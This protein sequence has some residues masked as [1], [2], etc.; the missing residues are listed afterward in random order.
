MKYSKLIYSCVFGLSIV[1]VE[2]A[3]GIANQL[4]LS[5]LQGW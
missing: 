3:D 5:L 2:N 1:L 4:A